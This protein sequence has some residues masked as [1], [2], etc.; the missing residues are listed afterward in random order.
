M[1][2]ILEFEIA[3]YD[4]ANPSYQDWAR[5]INCHFL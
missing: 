2:E 4:Y 5:P 1:Q 3:T